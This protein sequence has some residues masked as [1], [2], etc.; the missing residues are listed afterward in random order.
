MQSHP[1]DALD[2]LEKL[3]NELL[4]LEFPQALNVEDVHWLANGLLEFINGNK[5]SVDEALGLKKKAGRAE[6]IRKNQLIA[7]EWA[8]TANRG[9]T[10][11]ELAA[12]LQQKYP[13]TFAENLDEKQIR[14]VIGGKTLAKMTPAARIA[15]GHEVANRLNENDKKKGHK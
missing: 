5:S 8:G 3:A 1:D 4:A 11:S 9:K 7:Q 13:S 2:K 10:Y 12:H 6:Q 15:I 14:R